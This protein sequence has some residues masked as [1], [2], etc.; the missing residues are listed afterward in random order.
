MPPFFQDTFSFRDLKMHLG[1]QDSANMP[2]LWLLNSTVTIH[3]AGVRLAHAPSVLF[4]K[5]QIMVTLF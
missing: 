3:F 2:W 1:L 5:D 4:F